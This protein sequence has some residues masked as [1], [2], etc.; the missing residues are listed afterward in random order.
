MLLRTA[1][2]VKRKCMNYLFWNFPIP[3]SSQ[4]TPT[5]ENNLGEEPLYLLT[6][7]LLNTTEHSA[8]EQGDWKDV[9]DSARHQPPPL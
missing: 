5:G 8:R 7:C 6:E 1:C 4:I 2:N 3:R 9:E